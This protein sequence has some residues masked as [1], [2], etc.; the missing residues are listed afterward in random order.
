MKI[1]KK[2]L[3]QT[4]R[5]FIAYRPIPFEH[6]VG[7][8]VYPI[9]GA[10]YPHAVVIQGAAGPHRSFLNV[11][12]IGEDGRFSRLFQCSGDGRASPFG[13]LT[14]DGQVLQSLGMIDAFDEYA[15]D[16]SGMAPRGKWGSPK[17]A[18]MDLK[19]RWDDEFRRVNVQVEVKAKLRRSS[20]VIRSARI[21]R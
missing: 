10:I 15:A 20:L 6:L 7:L 12:H 14:G 5:G 11:Y 2:V 16:F 21:E 8:T 17:Q 1:D 9:M 4:D 18:Y 3:V 13:P 19:D